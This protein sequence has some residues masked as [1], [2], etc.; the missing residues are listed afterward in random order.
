MNKILKIFD[1]NNIKEN[2]L[3]FIVRIIVSVL[4]GLSYFLDSILVFNNSKVST[5][6]EFTGHEYVYFENPTVNSFV[7]L[8]VVTIVSFFII[9]ILGFI[10][11]KIK[12]KLWY[13]SEKKKLS[14]KKVFLIIFI[15]IFLMYLPYALTFF[16]SGYD[17]NTGTVIEQA[18]GE[19]PVTNHYPVLFIFIISLFLNLGKLINGSMYTG[20]IIYSLLQFFFM[21]GMISYFIYWWYKRN[22]SKKVIFALILFFGLFKLYPLYA[23][24]VWKETPFSLLVILLS[25]QIGD[26]VLSKGEKL[27]ENKFIALYILNIILISCLR[28]NGIY[29]V[30]ATTIFIIFTYKSYKKFIISFITTASII[31]IVQ[32]PIF[33]LLKINSEYVEKIGIPLQQIAYVLT[34]DGNITDEQYSYLESIM[35]T[36][37][38]KQNYRPWNVD[39]IKFNSDIKEDII[40]N[41][42]IKFFKTWLELFFQ[43]PEMYIEAYVLHITGF[44]N[45]NRVYNGDIKEYANPIINQADHFSFFG[46][47]VDLIR[48]TT[49]FSLRKY[50]FSFRDEQEI[51]TAI[52]VFIILISLTYITK[53]KRYK[54]IL[55]YLPTLF[56]L[57]T[58]LIATPIA[59]GLRYVYPVVLFA[60]FAVLIPFLNLD[61]NINDNKQ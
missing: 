40:K 7:I 43:N 20:Y 13:K 50:M 49:G 6:W 5:Y 9:S 34:Y 37:L 46:R 24:T 25:T 58:L 51:S 56:T 54:L 1:L 17:C 57:G 10:A 32:G 31:V 2:K 60:P 61:K 23:V 35:S 12:D 33:N 52:F 14:G 44:W 21:V 38:V 42:K 15:T 48:E 30:I 55:I 19:R 16:P 8:F 26:I 41:D 45:V 18:I 47:Q 39:F 28:N 29:I 3:Y 36:E 53:T 59:F 22:F 4:L 11:S 27:K